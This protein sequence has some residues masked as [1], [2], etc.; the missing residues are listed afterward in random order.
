[1]YSELHRKSESDIMFSP[2][3]QII[4][5]CFINV[6]LPNIMNSV[7]FFFF[8]LRIIKFTIPIRGTQEFGKK[9]KKNLSSIT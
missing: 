7:I 2:N 1:M 4:I 6:S 9:K 5:T 8:L 3:S